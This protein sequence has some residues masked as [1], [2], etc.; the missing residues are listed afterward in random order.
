MWWQQA[1]N[2]RGTKVLYNMKTNSADIAKRVAR[3][4]GAAIAAA[5][6]TL[7]LAASCSVGALFDEELARQDAVVVMN[8]STRISGKAR[9]PDWRSRPFTL[10][11]ADGR[12]L[13]L[14]PDSTAMVAFSRKGQ[15][16]ACSSAPHTRTLEVACSLRPG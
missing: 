14:H 12:R 6:A 15:A 7:S 5:T 2:R 11:A 3:Q 16:P 1:G 4:A 9:L 8:D 13:R 10:S